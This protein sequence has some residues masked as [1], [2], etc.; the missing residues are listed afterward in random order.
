MSSDEAERSVL[1]EFDVDRFNFAK[2]AG[3]V[4]P[5]DAHRGGPDPR[6]IDAAKDANPSWWRRFV[7]RRR[8]STNS[9]SDVR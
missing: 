5:T 1:M 6:D 3:K 9:G 2:G 7:D 8:R 4:L